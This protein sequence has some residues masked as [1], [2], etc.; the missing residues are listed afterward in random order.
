MGLLSS[1]LSSKEL[2]ILCRELATTYGAGIPIL[3]TLEL[4]AQHSSSG[5][6]RHMLERIGQSILDGQSFDGAV[7][8]ESSLLPDMFIE[9]IHA[10]EI[11][12]KLDVLLEDLAAYYENIWKMVRSVQA[13]MVYPLL[14]L[15][16][17]WY[18]GTFALGIVGRFNPYATERFVMRDY[19]SSYL[20]FHVQALVIFALVTG[21]LIALGRA[22]LLRMPWALFK[23]VIWPIRHI[24]NKFAMARFFQT[25]G[26]L[27]GSGLNMR[28]CI[29]RSAAVTMNPLIEQDLLKA[30]P[31]LMDGG[32]LVQAFS[33]CGYINRVGKEMIAV[34]EKSGR[35]DVTLKKVAEYHYNE[36]QAA[37]NTA[38]KLL[39]VAT[40][41]VVG[42]IIG[43]IVIYFYANMYGSLMTG[44]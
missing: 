4:A 1:Q 15:L 44:I 21:I 11:G 12:G 6:I 42:V 29:E 7:R 16:S 43:A 39:F 38:T 14:Q 31:V 34:G 35:L 22:G 27:I 28:Q 5:K 20:T 40:V 13:A 10:G 9:V 33:G 24:S 3:Q 26:L 18:L 17:A 2:A 41:L 30:I 32:T 25:L 36:A 37:V 8:A 23:N 19:L